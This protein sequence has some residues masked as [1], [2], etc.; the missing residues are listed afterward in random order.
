ML[1]QGVWYA[2]ESEPKCTSLVSSD[3]CIKCIKKHLNILSGGFRKPKDASNK[4]SSHIIRII[5]MSSP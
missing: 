5:T 3:A 4:Q 1:L 2:S